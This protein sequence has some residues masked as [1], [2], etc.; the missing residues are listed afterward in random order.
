[1]AS[2]AVVGTLLHF[3]VL[4]DMQP[5]AINFWLVCIPVVMMGAFMGAYLVEKIHRLTI[6]YLLYAIIVIQFIVALFIIRPSLQLVVVSAVTFLSG[7]GIFFFLAM[8]NRL[9][10]ENPSQAT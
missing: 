8:A 9:N 5:E 10:K 6:A 3:F 4:E 2:N 7:I 1:M